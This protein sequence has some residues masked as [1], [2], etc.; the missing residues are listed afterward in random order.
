MPFNTPTLSELISRAQ[1]DLSGD[2]GLRHSD[3]QV[4]ARVQAGAHFG[5]YGHQKWIADQLL[6]DTCE[7]E[8]LLRLAALRPIRDRLPAVAATG[9][10]SF[11][12]AVG[13]VLDAGTLLQR[14]D[15]V[16]IRVAEDVTLTAAAGVAVL[17]AVDAGVLGNTAAGAKLKLVSPVLG[18]VDGFTVTGDGLT[19]G[20]DQES[21]DALRVRVIRSYRQLPHGGN[22][23]DYVTWALE[24]PGVTRA[25]QRRHWVGPGT[26]GVFIMRDGDPD[27]FPNAAAL[28]EAKA[29]IETLRPTTAELYVMAPA[30]KLVAY[31][32]ALTPDSSATRASVE[33]SLRD[34]HYRES[35]PGVTLLRTHI[36]EAI[37]G[38][39]GERDHNL[40]APAA[41]VTAAGNEVLTFGGIVWG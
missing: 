6:P 14:D 5:L 11:A 29:Y 19:G 8:M 31:Q 40:I 32:I 13:A 38:S 3:A 27:P 2:E 7:E 33:A 21:I 36:A 28:A 10:A 15:G 22:A 4:A 26:V 35:E 39:A 17:E 16:L 37:S 34:L 24:V 30:P 18:I 23:D 12:G 41:D 9:A 1:A 20:T 25:W